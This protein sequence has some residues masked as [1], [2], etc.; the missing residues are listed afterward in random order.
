MWKKIKMENVIVLFEVTIKEDFMKMYLKLAQEL[1]EELVKNEGFL[2]SERYT[3]L[4]T[5]GKI[6]SK[7]VW[8]D[9]ESIEKWRNQIAHRM[10]QKKGRVQGFIDYQITVVSP[11]R[12]YTLSNRKEAPKDSNEFFK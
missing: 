10:C 7:S 8:K 11:R 4:N 6:L 2:S 1:K 5:K 9:E 3:C 12:T